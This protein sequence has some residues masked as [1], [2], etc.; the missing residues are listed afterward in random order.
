MG[1]IFGDE[2]RSCS[3]KILSK[4]IVNMY[5]DSERMVEIAEEFVEIW[6]AAPC[7]SNRLQIVRGEK[8]RRL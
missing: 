6:G 2:L 7:L 1:E 3:F 4:A 8:C 5:S